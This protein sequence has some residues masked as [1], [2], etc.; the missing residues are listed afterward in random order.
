[1]ETLTEILSKPPHL[2]PFSIG[3]TIILGTILGSFLNVVIY[4]WGD[5]NQTQFHPLNPPRSFCPNCKKTLSW[6]ENIPIISYLIQKGKCQHCQWSIPI[7]YPIVELSCSILLTAWLTQSP[8]YSQFLLGT[9]LLSTLLCI[10]VTDIEHQIIPN[11]ILITSSLLTIPLLIISHPNPLA[12]ILTSLGALLVMLA[13]SE[14]GKLLFGKKT[15]TLQEETPFSWSTEGI[16]IQEKNTPLEHSELIK[17]E[18]LFLRKSDKLE[19]QGKIQLEKDGTIITASTLTLDHTGI[20]SPDSLK[21]T[22]EVKGTIKTIT[23]PRE[24]MGMGDTKLV[25]FCGL[26]LSITQLSIGLTI[27]S[28]SALIYALALR[29]LAISR[30]NNPPE[31]IPFGPWISLGFLIALLFIHP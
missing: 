7:K 20:I 30:K 29:F 16:K 4:R 24:A 19:I 9:I 28:A 31:L 12:P 17:N 1:M 23:Y 3:I 8:S 27:A 6:K 5:P 2:S 15:I 25:G 11:K 10:T 21:G 14:V 26:F 22:N 13:I 18:E